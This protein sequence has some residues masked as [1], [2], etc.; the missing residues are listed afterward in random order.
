MGDRRQILSFDA[1]RAIAA[2]LVMSS[3]VRDVLLAE[4]RPALG[5][6]MW[7][8]YLLTSLGHPAVTIFFVLSGFW[9]TKV[10]VERREAGTWSW[11]GY[12]LDRLSRL[13]VVLLPA[14]LL[15]AAADFVTLRVLHFP[16]PRWGSQSIPADVDTHFT[17]FTFFA[18]AA[19]LQGQFS[20]AFGTNG[21]LWSLANEFWYYLWFPALYAAVAT[22]R[23][24]LPAILAIGTAIVFH[25]FLPGFVCWLCGSALYAL[26]RR[27]GRL[28][29]T[30]GVLGWAPFAALFFVDHD[31]GSGLRDIA[32]AVA[33]ILPFWRAKDW[34]FGKGAR[35][36]AYG[37]GSSYSLYAMHYP[38][39]ALAVA[40]LGLHQRLQPSVA[41]IGGC[42]VLCVGLALA[43]WAFSQLT[44]R[45][46]KRVRQWVAGFAADLMRASRPRAP[47]AG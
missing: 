44:E 42:L 35:L 8:F 18:N 22:R 15:G 29:A 17:L 40:A 30:W 37:A 31:S 20:Y 9:I 14:L 21:P 2:L 16:P 34:P 32:L 47:E 11:G 36:A 19:F 12:L 1:L 6:P 13:W 26:S 39:L 46:T 28:N 43:T 45:N 33:C 23:I 10:V 3:H 41:A 7:L 4:W 27:Y 5:A 38:L 25:S 24:T